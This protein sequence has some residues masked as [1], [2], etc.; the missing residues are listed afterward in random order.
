MRGNAAVLAEAQAF[1][2]ASIVSRPDLDRASRLADD[3]DAKG[4]ISAASALRNLVVK[5]TSSNPEA[6]EATA[7]ALNSIEGIR[8]A[9]RPQPSISAG[10]TSLGRISFDPTAPPKVA[11]LFSRLVDL[12]AQARSDPGAFV[13]W[14]R[15]VLST[16]SRNR[17]AEIVWSLPSAGTAEA[18]RLI[19]TTPGLGRCTTDALTTMPDANEVLLEFISESL[20]STQLLETEVDAVL[21]AISALVRLGHSSDSL[22]LA[23][24]PHAELR[25]VGRCLASSGLPANGDSALSRGISAILRYD[26]ESGQDSL[27]SWLADA[28]PPEVLRVGRFVAGWPEGEASGAAAL[29]RWLN[30]GNLPA[31]GALVVG[32]EPAGAAS[33]LIERG[34]ELDHALVDLLPSLASRIAILSEGGQHD[35]DDNESAPLDPAMAYFSAGGTAAAPTDSRRDETPL[36]TAGIHE[37]AELAANGSL[38]AMGA[39]TASQDLAARRYE[40]LLLTSVFPYIATEAAAAVAARGSA[41]ARY[42]SHLLDSGDPS[43]LEAA[44]HIL[45]KC[46]LEDARDD[47]LDALGS[48]DPWILRA[49]ASAAGQAAA[50][51]ADREISRA[52][53]NAMTRIAG[54]ALTVVPEIAAIGNARAIDQVVKLNERGQLFDSGRDD[55]LLA[56]LLASGDQARQGAIGRAEREREILHEQW[57]GEG[58]LDNFGSGKLH[59]LVKRIRNRGGS[60]K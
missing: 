15:T 19:L 39:I 35:A 52:L 59:Q 10:A 22:E 45:A 49:A 32:A 38:A 41:G 21:A 43:L 2:E 11:Q 36:G 60:A 26:S 25:E 47:L 20:Q 40:E 33:M 46:A 24:A 27:S 4:E 58:R 28:A 54:G 23:D 6:L 42:A 31:Y 16:T 29:D 53:I 50:A 8:C 51:T 5:A 34:R 56:E 3:C 57:R 7:A 13:A 17:R 30:H 18:A 12:S 9:G 48:N 44:F 14:S 55:Q 37:L 1:L